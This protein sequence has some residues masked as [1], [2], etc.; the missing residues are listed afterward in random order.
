LETG[1]LPT[2]LHPYRKPASPP[3]RAVSSIGTALIAR[4]KRFL[5]ARAKR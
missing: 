2:E 4:A 1:T 5:I 3:I